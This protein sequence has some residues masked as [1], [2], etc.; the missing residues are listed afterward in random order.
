MPLINGTN[1][2]VYEGDVALGHSVNATLSM[3]MDVPDATTKTSGGWFECIGGKRSAKIKVEGLVDYSDQLNYNQL[4]D[5]LILKKETQWVFKGAS[6]FYFGAGKVVSVEE[7]SESEKSVSYAV[8]IEISGRVY[9]EPRLPWNLVFQNWENI[10]I[11]W[12]NV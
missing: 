1:I 2:L 7:V 8:D 12:E 3:A 11:N 9:F 5:R 10:N 6:M 4:V